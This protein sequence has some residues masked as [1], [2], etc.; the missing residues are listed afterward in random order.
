[1]GNKQEINAYE[2]MKEDRV[3][4]GVPEKIS[5]NYQW[6]MEALLG[7][8]FSLIFFKLKTGI[9]VPPGNNR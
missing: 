7:K 2:V 3:P 5:V 8:T 4:E 9:F 6:E 1:M